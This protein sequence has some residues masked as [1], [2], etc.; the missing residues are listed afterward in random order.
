MFDIGFSELLL[1]ALVALVVLGPE[2]LPKA[3]RFAGLWVR[4]ARAQWHSVKAELEHELAADELK[5]SLQQT[6]AQLREAQEEL[7]SGLNEARERLREEE[8]ALREEFERGGEEPALESSSRP[9]ELPEGDETAPAPDAGRGDA[10]A[11]A[12]APRSDA[13]GERR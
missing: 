8:R 10:P 1:I 5:R 13:S 7:R 9:L 6:E 11:E 12:P 3:A 4:R 2:R